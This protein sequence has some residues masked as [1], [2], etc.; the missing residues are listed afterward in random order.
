MR[1]RFDP[2]EL[3]RRRIESGKKPEL[4]ALEIDRTKEAYSSYERGIA[5]PPTPVL[6]AIC[7]ALGCEPADL[8]VIDH[9]DDDAARA[10]MIAGRAAQGLPTELPDD[11][12]ETAAEL[13]RLSTPASAS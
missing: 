5:T 3:K 11:E 8:L 2:V 6:L 7:D 4:I 10:D 12:V 13:L 9:T 1:Y